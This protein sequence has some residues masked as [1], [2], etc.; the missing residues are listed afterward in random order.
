MTLQDV[1]SLL[2]SSGYPVAYRDYTGQVKKDIPNPPFMVY[3][4]LDTGFDGGDMRKFI[5]EQDINVELYT[6]GKDLEAEEVV[7]RLLIDLDPE[8][9]E[10]NNGYIKVNGTDVKV[11][12]HSQSDWNETD[13]TAEGYIKNKPVI[14]EGVVVDTELSD[15]STNA[16]ANKVVKAA[17]DGKLNLT[18]KLILN[19]TL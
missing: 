5:R 4:V 6:D 3:S 8:K 19:C 11:Y 17:L 16:I 1:Y 18:D 10:A 13:E 12:E 14:P 15:T 7:D 9:Y 2:L